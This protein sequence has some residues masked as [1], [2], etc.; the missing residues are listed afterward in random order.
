MVIQRWQTVFLFFA[1]VIMAIFAFTNFAEI[2]SG[3]EN[4]YSLSPSHYL[5]WLT[6]NIVITLMLFIAIFLYRNI[7]FQKKVTL[8][9]I[10]MIAASAVTGGLT[11]YGPQAD[12]G[13]T[14]ELIWGGGVTL[15]IVAALLAIIAYRRMS[16]D[17][18]LLN[19]SSR[20]R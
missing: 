9:S 13:G 16:A 19:E 17:E 20:L 8:I 15:L 7:R 2:G 3:S 11:L 14:V 10:V 1:S 6:L 5:G 18:R 12:F 4:A